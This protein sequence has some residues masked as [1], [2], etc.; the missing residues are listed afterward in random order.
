MPNVCPQNAERV[1]EK[2]PLFA[3]EISNFH[4]PQFGILGAGRNRY[5]QA[6][7]FD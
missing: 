1:S 6:D 2:R 3:E 7:R 5:R 4:R